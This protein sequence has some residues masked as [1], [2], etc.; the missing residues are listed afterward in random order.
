MDQTPSTSTIPDGGGNGLNPV[1]VMY[2]LILTGEKY[3]KVK[4]GYNHDDNVQATCVNCKAIIKGNLK[5]TS[6]F[7]LHLKVSM[8][9][10][11]CCFIK[12]PLSKCMHLY[13]C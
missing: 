4:S 11:N 8:Y 5:A 2:P 9:I 10:H 1:N 13:A 12:Y 3:F 6:N 7:R